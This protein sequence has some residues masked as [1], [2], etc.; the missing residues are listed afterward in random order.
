MEKIDVLCAIHIYHSNTQCGQT[1][2]CLNGSYGGTYS[3]HWYLEGYT[4]Q[5]VTPSCRTSELLLS[6]AAAT[7]VQF[8]RAVQ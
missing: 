7:S 2:Q 8:R 1:V 3:N 5:Y 6:V 4:R